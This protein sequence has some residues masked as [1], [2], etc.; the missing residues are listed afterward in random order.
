MSINSVA[1]EKTL[2][3]FYIRKE[4]FSVM[5]IFGKTEQ[6]KF[7][8]KRNDFSTIIQTLF[9]KATCYHD[10]KWIIIE[11]NHSLIREIKSMIQIKRKPLQYTS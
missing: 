1:A 10:G 7:E 2:C 8:E 4:T 9:D 11:V 3:A 6:E 5:V